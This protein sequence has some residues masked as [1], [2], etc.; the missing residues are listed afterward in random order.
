MPVSTSSSGS[1]IVARGDTLSGIAARIGTS[2]TALAAAN[3]LD[4]N[5]ILPEGAALRL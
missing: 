1:Y 3:G 4:V 2:A 5:G